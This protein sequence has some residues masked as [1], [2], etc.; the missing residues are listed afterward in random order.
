MYILI[1]DKLYLSEV[2][3]NWIR[4]LRSTYIEFISIKFLIWIRII[5]SSFSSFI[6]KVAILLPEQEVIY[7]HP[8][9]WKQLWPKAQSPLA[10]PL[11]T[12]GKGTNYHSYF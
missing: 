7:K 9:D 6:F 5:P 1:K 3:K 8:T 12:A 2:D 10:E 4:S 11:K